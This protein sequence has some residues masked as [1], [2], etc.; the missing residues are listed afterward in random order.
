MN[1]AS[2]GLCEADWSCLAAPPVAMI[3]GAEVCTRLARTDRVI[4]A[5]C[6]MREP[7]PFSVTTCSIQTYPI[8]IR[9]DWIRQDTP[10]HLMYKYLVILFWLRSH[11]IILVFRFVLSPYD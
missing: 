7:G 8:L 5:L 1:G 3:A 10:C 4:V 9:L 2:K 6:N 11:E